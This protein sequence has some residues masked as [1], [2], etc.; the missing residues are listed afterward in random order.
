MLFNSWAFLGFAAIVLPLYFVLPHRWQNRMLLLASYAFYAAWD[1]RFCFLLAGSTVLDYSCASAM[2]R[3]GTRTERRPFLFAS[4]AF[5]LGALGFFKYFNFFVDSFVELVGQFGLAP[6]TPVL[7]IVLPVGISFYTFQTLAYTIDVYRDQETPTRDFTAFALY[8]AYFPQLV[9]GPIERSTR[10]LPQSTKPR[11]VNKTMISTGLQLMLLGYFKKMGVADAVAPYVDG[12]FDDPAAHSSLELLFSVYLFA[13]QIY[14]DFSGY[15]DIARGLSRLLGIELMLNFKQPYLSRNVTE[16]WRRWHISLS[17][18]LRDYLYIPLGGNRGGPSATYR[19]LMLTM[20]LGGLWH[21]AAWT[22]VIWGGLQG[23]YLAVHRMWMGASRKAEMPPP[24][25]PRQ[26]LGFGVNAVITFHLICLA[27][28]FFRADSVASAIGVIGGIS[29]FDIDTA[30]LGRAVAFFFFG[31]VL[32]LVDWPSWRHDR[33]LP[34]GDAVPAWRRGLVYATAIAFI[35]FLGES[36]G[37][38]FIYF[39][40]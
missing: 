4:L 3:R 18:W 27:W 28:I 34:L 21:G 22:F 23:L 11:R 20:L 26:W 14:C 36:Q 2:A 32:L 33:E 7:E 29:A 17:T 1:W 16:F 24:R 37:A 25:T 31:G 5:N 30:F 40:F 39:Q 38:P 12:C 13:L 10:L 6:S 15:T 19:N 9:A 35:S 8:V